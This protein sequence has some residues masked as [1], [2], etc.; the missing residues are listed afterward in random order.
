MS[1]RAM[2]GGA[3]LPR[4]VAEKNGTRRKNELDDCSISSRLCEP[5]GLRA[6]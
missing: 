2:K 3:I 6:V 4:N 1:R 5:I